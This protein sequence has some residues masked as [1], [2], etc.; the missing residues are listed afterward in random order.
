MSDR[1]TLLI[2]IVVRLFQRVR[3]SRKASFSALAA[4]DELREADKEWDAEFLK[5]WQS[6]LPDKVIKQGNHRHL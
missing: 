6:K 3:Q 2:R 1:Q 4:P 5:K